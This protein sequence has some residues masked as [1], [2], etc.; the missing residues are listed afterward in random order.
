M[1]MLQSMVTISLPAALVTLFFV[2]MIVYA[3]IIKPPS[4]TAALIADT[5]L[6]LRSPQRFLN[7]L[8]ILVAMVMFNKAMLD[9]KPS[10]PSLVPFAWDEAFMQLDRR[11]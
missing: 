6:V 2:H 11:N 7:G 10:I 3:F 5:F 4:P 9:L 8:P 1:A